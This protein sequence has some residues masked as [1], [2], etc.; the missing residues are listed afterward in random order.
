MDS[1]SWLNNATGQPIRFGNNVPFNMIP[2]QQLEAR[3]TKPV[4]VSEL[5]QGLNPI[6]G[7]QSNWSFKNMKE[8]NQQE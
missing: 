7:Q 4:N 1:L 6:G 8:T 3:Q 5:E 2:V